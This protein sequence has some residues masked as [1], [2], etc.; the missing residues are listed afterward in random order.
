MGFCFVWIIALATGQ[1][2]HQLHFLPLDSQSFQIS[3][4]P[5]EYDCEFSN[6][7]TWLIC[8]LCVLLIVSISLN[9]LADPT[10][11]LTDI[12]STVW[13]I[14]LTHC[15]WTTYLLLYI[16]ITNNTTATC[17]HLSCIYKA[18]TEPGHLACLVRSPYGLVW[19]LYWIFGITI[20]KPGIQIVPIS[21]S[22]TCHV[23]TMAHC[24]Y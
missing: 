5:H 7:A 24:L 10:C 18:L 20:I 3:G 19:N 17:R 1:A 8:L 12:C 11:W 23:Q 9:C 22:R 14:L 6:S 21:R 2:Y 4:V 16:V 15:L 13:L